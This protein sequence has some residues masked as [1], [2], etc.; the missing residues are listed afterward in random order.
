MVQ[1]FPYGFV[2]MIQGMSL[3]EK[4]FA[5]ASFVCLKSFDEMKG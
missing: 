3:F 4:T 1:E 2:H 5:V